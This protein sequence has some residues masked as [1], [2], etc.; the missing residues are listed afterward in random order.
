MLS[1]VETRPGVLEIGVIAPGEYQALADLHGGRSYLQLAAWAAVKAEWTSELLA[2]RATDGTVVGTTLVLL[3]RLPGVSRWYA[4]LPEGPDIDWSDPRL[5]RWLDPLLEHLD[6]RQVFAV[7]LGPP[8]ALRRWQAATLKSAGAPGRQVDDVLPDVV[9]PLGSAV[10]ERL[11]TLGWSRGGE[12]GTG[13]DAQPRYQFQVPLAG[14]TD[15]ELWSGLSK[16]W[17]RNIQKGEKSGVRIR[18]GTEA[19]LPAFFQLLQATERR[20]GFRLGRSL[21][22]YE[23]QYRVLNAELQGRMRLYLSTYRDEVLAAHTMNVVG[24]RVWYQSGGS[25]NHRRDVRPSHVLQWRMMSD[26][27][28]LGAERYDMRGVS[29]CLDP[30]DPA[31]GLL[32]WKLGTGGELIQTVGEWE[33]PLPGPVN[34]LLLRAMTRYRRRG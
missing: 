6:R 10:V 5:E 8:P 4:Y 17:R 20:N 24:R 31:F 19:D 1:E 27:H 11:R 15:A 9:E 23:R 33:R 14:R 3:R 26:A 18:I 22:Y 13:G 21:A 29:G 32:R 2:W 28:Q 25:A 16:E 12:D 30:T 34:Q 7:R